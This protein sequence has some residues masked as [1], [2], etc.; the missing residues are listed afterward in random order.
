MIKLFKPKFWDSKTI[1]IFS[2]LLFPISLVTLMLIFFKKRFTKPKKFK[3]PIICV[4]NIYIGGTGKTP[5]SILLSK[6]LSILGFKPVILRKF[7]S[8]HAD[9][10]NQIRN[11]FNNLIISKDRETGII[12]A[13]EKGYNIVILD[14]GFQDYN[15]KKNLNIICFNQN[16]LVGNGYVLPA[17][18]LRES[19]KSLL[20]VDFVLINGKHDQNF[21]T[22]ILKINRNLEIF[23]SQYMPVNLNEFS[24]QKLLAVAGIANP[25]N[26]FMLLKKNN[27]KI[28]KKLVFPDHHRFTKKD[29]Q[30]II[31]IATKNNLKIITT[32]K[33]FFKIEDFKLSEFNY[34]KVS[35]QI[36]EK[37]KL[38]YKIKNYL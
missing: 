28:E 4:G 25:E 1:S 9:E 2:I 6:E 17:G 15:I 33:D 18:P 20:N 27:L 14:D 13:Q 22:K 26:F 31:K 34:L 3:I 36:F 16:Q 7:Y 32:E 19:L 23:Y 30:N 11:N 35:L 38:L 8:N 21:E 10:Y 24:G 5:T 29:L 37:E 12:K